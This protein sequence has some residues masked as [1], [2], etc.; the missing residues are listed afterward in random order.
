MS[1]DSDYTASE[2]KGKGARDANQEPWLSVPPDLFPLGTQNSL[3]WSDGIYFWRD[4][5]RECFHKS[6]KLS[7]SPHAVVDSSC[8]VLSFFEMYFL[9]L[10]Q[11]FICPTHQRAVSFVEMKDH[12][13]Q[14]HKNAAQQAGF[15]VDPLL[16]HISRAFPSVSL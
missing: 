12:L 4:K 14:M 3:K 11:A 1:P 2:S 9:P 7:I 6:R 16:S 8:C 13:I 5:Y 15:K 10:T